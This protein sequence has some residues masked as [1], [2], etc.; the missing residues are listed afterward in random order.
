MVATIFNADA[1]FELIVMGA[2]WIRTRAYRSLSRQLISTKIVD[3][4]K[5]VIEVI[6]A[7]LM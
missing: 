5:Y 7:M 3:C 6:C 2:A 1:M 4:V